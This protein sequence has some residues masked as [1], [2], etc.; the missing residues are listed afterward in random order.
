MQTPSGA[1]DVTLESLSCGYSMC[2]P[3]DR[4]VQ[5]VLTSFSWKVSA[6]VPRVS[7]KQAQF[8]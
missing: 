8:V 7:R 6:R 1:L 4:R 3:L 5:R 2:S